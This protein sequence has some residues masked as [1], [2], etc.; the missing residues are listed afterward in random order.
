MQWRVTM[1]DFVEGENALE[2]ADAMV[3]KL[4]EVAEHD[5]LKAWVYMRTRNVC[6]REFERAVAGEEVGDDS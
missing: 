5:E 4:R 3:D 6:S 1:V 2:A